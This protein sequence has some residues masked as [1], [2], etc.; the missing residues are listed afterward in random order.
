MKP[1]ST[2]Y[3]LARPGGEWNRIR[4]LCRRGGMGVLHAMWPTVVAERGGRVVGVLATQRRDDMILAGPLAIEGGSNP[5]MFIRLVEAYE[6]VL[7]AAHIRSYYFTVDKTNESQ[8]ARVQELGISQV[9][10]A[11]NYLIFK[12]EL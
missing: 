6:N 2:L 8:I 3:R 10:D 7:R 4:S 1:S 11:N 9:E 5:I 12:R